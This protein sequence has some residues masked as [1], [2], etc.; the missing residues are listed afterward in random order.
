MIRNALKS[1][2][3]QID[4]IYNQAIALGF[5]TAHTQPLKQAERLIWFEKYSPDNY[6]L[7][8]FE[9]D[10]QV[11]GWLS[12]SPYRQGRQALNETV[13]ISFYIDTAHKREGIGYKLIQ[14]AIEYMYRINKRVLIAIVIES[15]TAS[16]NLLEKLGFEKWGF[17]PEV[18]HFQ[19]KIKGQI[20]MGRILSLDQS[21]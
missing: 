19:N 16:I 3:K 10:N 15:N 11:V 14:H 9:K 1:D 5:L 20:Y 4:A 8:V 13:E 2:L 17:L 21:I 12:V 6:P 18:V 7:F